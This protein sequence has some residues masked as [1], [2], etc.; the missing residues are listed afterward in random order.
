LNDRYKLSFQV[1]AGRHFQFAHRGSPT[2]RAEL[3]RYQDRFFQ[4]ICPRYFR[5]EPR[6]P[7]RIV[8]FASAAEYTRAT[9]MR[10]YGHY[11]PAERTLYS[12]TGSGHGT[13]WHE[14]IHAFLDDQ[15]VGFVPQWFEEGFAA[16][17]EMA[18]LRGDRVSEGCANWRLPALQQAIR[19]GRVTPLREALLMEDFTPGF[20]YAEARFFFCW[21]WTRGIL[22]RFV[23]IFVYE[24]LPH[25]DGPE[26]GR[27][28]I[29][30]LEEL[31]A[32][33]IDEID[34]E[35]RALALRTRKNQK[36]TRE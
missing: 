22:Q 26:L 24:L 16:F 21:L 17:Y 35:Y 1:E 5:Y 15:S 19:A 28:A 3:R 11:S 13:L 14:M 12:Y 10:T 23:Q 4:E 31:S 18:F 27:A 7:W 20:H 30:T 8:Y 25:H 36:L 34:R 32:L 6:E 9:G 29:Q 33:T 2:R